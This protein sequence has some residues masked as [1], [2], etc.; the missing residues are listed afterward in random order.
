MRIKNQ[1]SGFFLDV[2]NFLK[3]RS[4]LGVDIGTISI[5]IAELTEQKGKLFLNNYGI[6]E[7]KEYLNYPNK[8]LQGSSLLIDEKV[9]TEYL[10]ILLKEMKPKIELAIASIPAF[11]SFTT[12]LEMPL[13]NN[14]EVS[15]VIKNQFSQYIPLPPNEV[16]VDWIKVD[17]CLSASNKKNQHILLIGIPIKVINAYKNIFKN[18]GLKLIF[19]ELD[20]LALVRTLIEKSDKD[21]VIVDIGGEET[22]IFIA[23]EG[24][25]AYATETPY[26]GIHLTQAIS[27]SLGISN[28]RAEQLKRSKSSVNQNEDTEIINLTLPFLD[29]IIQEVNQAIGVYKRK[30][31][32]IVE[33]IMVLGGAANLNWVSKYFAK[34]TGLLETKPEIFRKVGYNL[35]LEPI[36]RNLT[37]ELS[38]AISLAQKYFY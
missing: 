20:G 6:L 25:L 36:S 27:R 18:V 14:T 1:I 23:T 19:L 2:F 8:A 30:Y 37:N 4:I 26:S 38:L 28:F 33:R 16:V 21:T 29:V 10:N 24:N 17:E 9:A 5:K 12:V 34:Q 32:K 35:I 11:T 13:M 3:G 15:N 31:G 7:T 22:Q